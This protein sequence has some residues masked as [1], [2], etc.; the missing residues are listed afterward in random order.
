MCVVTVGAG[1]IQRAFPRGC[2]GTQEIQ[3]AAKIGNNQ[4]PAGAATRNPRS[5]AKRAQ[6]G[7]E[8]C[9]AADGEGAGQTRVL[10]FLG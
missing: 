3:T 8:G 6:A 7:G 4:D 9:L 1:S 5:S 2:Q 10:L